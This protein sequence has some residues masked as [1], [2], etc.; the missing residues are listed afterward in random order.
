MQT[1]IVQGAHDVVRGLLYSVESVADPSSA[2][3]SI[4]EVIDYLENETCL[5]KN[6]TPTECAFHLKVYRV[7]SAIASSIGWIFTI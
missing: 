3:P 6:G 1:T 7:L 2:S 5:K 4:R